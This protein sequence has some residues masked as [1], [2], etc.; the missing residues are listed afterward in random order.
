MAPAKTGAI[1][2]E[3]RMNIEIKGHILDM[4]TAPGLFSPAHADRGTMAM[5]SKVEFLPSEFV[6]CM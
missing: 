2:K 3:Q 4:E 1:I 5:L 6:V